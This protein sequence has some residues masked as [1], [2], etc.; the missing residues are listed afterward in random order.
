MRKRTLVARSAILFSAILAV[1]AVAG[2]GGC[3][4]KKTAVPEA[5]DPVIPV[6]RVVEREVTDY[7]DYTGRTDA[8]LAVNVRARSTGYLLQTRFEEGAIVKEGDFLFEI[9]PRPYEISVKQSK[10][11]VEKA[12]ASLK[13]LQATLD[14]DRK[15]F[16]V[17]AVSDLQIIADEANVEGAQATLDS[18]NASLEQADLN[19]SFTKV[20]APIS[21]QISRY[22]Y[23]PGN[24]ITQDQT[25]LTTIVSTDS[26]YAY[27][28]IEEHTF[29]RITDSISKTRGLPPVTLD[30]Q[31]L[32]AAAGGMAALTPVQ[33]AAF[34][35]R[36]AIE[37]QPD[38]PYK[39]KLD[40]IN[41]QVN[42]STGTVACRAF[43][44][45]KQLPGG[46][47]SL[48]PGR[49]VRIRL[50]L[51]GQ[52]KSQLIIDRAIG[53]DQGLKYVYVV[54]SENKVQYRR[55]FPGAI[56][57]DGLRVIEPYKPK[58]GD[59][60]ESGVKPDELVVVGGLQQLKPKLKIQPEL[61]PMPTNA[62]PILSRQKSAPAGPGAPG[63][64]GAGQ[65]SEKGGGG[66][67]GGKK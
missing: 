35:V 12:K 23:T 48:I 67:G 11:S 60:M 4:K 44:E 41:N 25:L 55:V 39:G 38:F 58:N 57:E 8:V 24:L 59:E 2:V 62:S 47:V 29:N 10:A 45:N 40:F 46:L 54:D 51:G 1:I 34:P 64:G 26:I 14:A 9:D 33:R 7:M 42:P 37:D 30:Y 61:Y 17:G 36:M 16:K 3:E 18:S 27:F 49:F 28:D 52:H 53:S 32:R 56:Q 6:S 13:N 22:N 15:G 21:G 31:C 5:Q 50:P 20:Y 66:K 65:K 43:F 19:L 63:P